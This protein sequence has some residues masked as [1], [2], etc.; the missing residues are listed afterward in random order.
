MKPTIRFT[1][2]RT[3]SMFSILTLL[4]LLS[5]F[6]LL[7]LLLVLSLLLLLSLP[8]LVILSL[9]LPELLFWSLLP[10]WLRCLPALL[11]RS[12]TWPVNRLQ[13]LLWLQLRPA[14]KLLVP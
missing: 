9:L 12:L 10:S 13:L 6:L 2:I 11:T 14:D 1:W 5:L 8:M 3:S 4:L 7:A